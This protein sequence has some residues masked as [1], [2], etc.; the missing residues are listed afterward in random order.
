[1]K[2]A[3]V[4]PPMDF[5]DESLSYASMMLGKW[6]IT[7]TITSYSSKQCVGYHGAVIRPHMNSGRINSADFDALLL[8]DGP[9]VD[10]SRLY[11]FRPLLDTVAFFNLNKKPVAAIGNAVKI[12]AK[13]NIISG[14]RVSLS[15]DKDSSNLV[16][17]FRGIQSDNSVELDH[18]ILSAGS[19]DNI[20]EFIDR[21]LTLMGVK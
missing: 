5:K 14:T 11:D 9:G 15:N 12:L 2:V 19:S 18:N 10:A 4:I 21:L 16:R 3:I 17:L 1:M 7:P 6:G 13:A 20:G 8:L